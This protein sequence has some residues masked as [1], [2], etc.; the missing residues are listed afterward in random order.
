[1]PGNRGVWWFFENTAPLLRDGWGGINGPGIEAACR[2]MGVPPAARPG[3]LQK[4]LILLSGQD[5]LQ[6]EGHEQ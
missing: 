1:M 5:Q 4:I 2:L 6:V 3:L